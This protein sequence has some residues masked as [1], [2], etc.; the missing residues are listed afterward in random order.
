[1]EN[2]IKY[3]LNIFKIK[4]VLN[5]MSVTI[6]DRE[7]D[8]ETT[9]EI[10]L[11]RYKFNQ[12]VLKFVNLKKLYFNFNKYILPDISTLINLESLECFYSKLTSLPELN[13]LVNLKELYV[14]NNKLKS[15]PDLSLLKNL[16]ELDCSINELMTLPDLS[17]LVSLKELEC[18]NNNLQI[19]PD[20]SKLTSLEK[21]NC[22][23]NDLISIINIDSLTNLKKFYCCNNP[24]LIP[25]TKLEFLTGLEVLSCPENK[26]TL[27]PDLS[28]LINLKVLDCTDNKLKTIPNLNWVS[29][30][31]LF[32]DNNEI[33]FFPSLN[34][35][36][37]L[38]MLHCSDNRLKSFP[39][40]SALTNLISFMFRYNEL[41]Y[42]P[43]L[44][45]SQHLQELFCENNMITVLPIFL[46]RLRLIY[47]NY[48][49]NPL[50]YI[51]PQVYRWL[52]RV[53][54]SGIKVYNDRQN[55]H[56][57]FIQ[58]S[59]VKSIE[60]I[61]SQNFK[62]NEEEILKEVLDDLVLNCKEQ[63]IDYMNNQDVHSTLQLTFKELFFFVWEMIKRSEYKDEI[64]K[65][66]NEEM[67]ESDCMC[68]TGR[69]SRLVNCLNGFSDLVNITISTKQQISNIVEIIRSGL[70]DNHT[71]EQY[72]TEII[73]ELTERGFPKE[74][75]D[76]WLL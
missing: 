41:N 43:D 28:S 30:K 5:I 36:V 38:T 18:A 2:L 10:N 52:N 16:Q 22:S 24:R 13:N 11:S 21:I 74:D 47:F 23:N 17:Q 76:E 40:L 15:L 73:K 68:F 49:G 44:S 7:Y 12:D 46:S 45:N 56:D 4:L 1:M 54:I 58:D 57:R 61:T 19:I 35:L 67:K 29:I 26:L 71:E 3:I 69:L 14:N 53:K 32:C 62:F 66:L 33:E 27:L 6:Y 34:Q 42:I 60:K 25:N 50:E 70:P 55:V 9:T 48:A 39:D 59:I 20:V 63:L 64:K 8:I 37:N 72:N 75:I 65:R 51:P 31:E